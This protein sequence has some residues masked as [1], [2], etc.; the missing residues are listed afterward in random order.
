MGGGHEKSLI[1]SGYEIAAI[2]AGQ[3]LDG[4]DAYV[5]E[6]ARIKDHKK[7]KYGQSGSDEKYYIYEQANDD[8]TNLFTTILDNVSTS[9]VALASGLGGLDAETAAM[10]YTFD[11]GKIELK[12]LDSDEINEMLSTMISTQADIYV[13]AILGGISAAD[14]YLRDNPNINTK[15]TFL[16]RQLQPSENGV[17]IEIYVFSKIHA[18][19]DYESVQ[20]DIFD[21]LFAVIPEFGLRLYQYPSGGDF[22]LKKK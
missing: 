3:I 6:Y 1:G 13:G 15:L 21:H 7:G 5:E 14:A 16:I 17:A 18:W 4:A 19:V 2:T 20:S 11:I 12:G 9:V 10:D 8:I 22:I